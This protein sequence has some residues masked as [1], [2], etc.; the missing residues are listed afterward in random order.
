LVDSSQKIIPVLPAE[1]ACFSSLDGLDG[2]LDNDGGLTH[3]FRLA[4]LVW[5]R[6]CIRKVATLLYLTSP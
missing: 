6:Q 1:V 5:L 2:A 3:P 4:A